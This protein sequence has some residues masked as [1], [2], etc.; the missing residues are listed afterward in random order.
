MRSRPLLVALVATSFTASCSFM[1]VD[2]P[3]PQS[4]AGYTPPCTTSNAWP[5]VDV[6]WTANYLLGAV[7]WASMSEEDAMKRNVSPGTAVGASLALGALALTSAIT[8]FNRV[9]DCKEQQV[10]EGRGAYRYQRVGTQPRSVR[11]REEAEEEAAAQ[12]RLRART[13]MPPEEAPAVAPEPT[14]AAAIEQAKAAGAAAGAA[15]AAP[16]PKVPAPAPPA[17]PAP[18]Q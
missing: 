3:Q 17:S 1:L 7:Y 9:N 8:G 16:A 11:Q 10:Q 4:R 2:G 12:A 13:V 15:A 18:K 5:V 6:L 14:D